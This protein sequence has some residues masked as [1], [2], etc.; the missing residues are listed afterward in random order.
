MKFPA[1]QV[2]VT[3]GSPLKGGVYERLIGLVKRSLRKA[4][5]N[6]S[7]LNVYLFALI[8]FKLSFG[9]KPSGQSAKS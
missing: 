8:P 7:N 6:S 4:I 3:N 2:M 9:Q 5:E 1:Q